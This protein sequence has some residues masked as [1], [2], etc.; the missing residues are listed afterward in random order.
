[1]GLPYPLDPIGGDAWTGY[2]TY[3]VAYTSRQG[4]RMKFTVFASSAAEAVSIAQASLQ[5]LQLFGPITNVTAAIS[6]VPGV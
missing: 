2:T 1:M 5:I 6:T 3:L 4:T